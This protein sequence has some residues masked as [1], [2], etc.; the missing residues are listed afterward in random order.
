MDDES[1]LKENIK[2][3]WDEYI[4][5]SDFWQMLALV[6]LYCL[7]I[8]SL[9]LAGAWLITDVYNLAGSNGGQCICPLIALV[10]A[11][12]TGV[13]RSRLKKR[14]GLTD[15]ART[16][17]VESIFALVMIV[18]LSITDMGY[19]S[20]FLG[21]LF[22]MAAFAAV[23]ICE[24]TLEIE[25]VGVR[26]ERKYFCILSGIVYILI[27]PLLDSGIHYP[28]Q[29][30]TELAWNQITL[31]VIL[32]L[33]HAFTLGTRT[34]PQRGV[35]PIVPKEN[36]QLTMSF[37]SMRTSPTSQT[38]RLLDQEGKRSKP[39]ELY[40]HTR[41]EDEEYVW[42]LSTFYKDGVVDGLVILKC[43]SEKNAEEED[44]KYEAVTDPEL[45][46]HLFNR[47]KK[48]YG[49]I[50]DF[51]EEDELVDPTIVNEEPTEAEAEADAESEAEVEPE[52]ETGSEVEFEDESEA[53]TE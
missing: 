34:Q 22:V 3:L 24:F 6:V 27:T 13:L 14:A 21:A 18:I 8:F 32:E 45:Y 33:V 9:F 12:A 1:N 7:H 5:H 36:K 4:G 43:L 53:T 40:G 51:F 42:L 35:W 39:L 10:A 26:F 48:Q 15:D 44:E 20:A 46:M 29:V 31:W 37:S 28:D 38:V 49:L 47:F 30:L 23:K 17:A 25:R 2:F 11:I 16:C 41:C 52:A 50:F 19:L